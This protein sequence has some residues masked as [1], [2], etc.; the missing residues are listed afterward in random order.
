MALL[1]A[2]LA[3]Q[4]QQQATL[5]TAVLE[6]LVHCV[7]HGLSTAGDTGAAVVF[8]AYGFAWTASTRTHGA[9]CIS[10]PLLGL[11]SLHLVSKLLVHAYPALLVTLLHVA[12]LLHPAGSDLQ[13]EL[14]AVL[15]H[16]LM[17][18]AAAL[19]QPPAYAAACQQL[20]AAA[21]GGVIP[22]S[23]SISSSSNAAPAAAVV[24]SS[25]MSSSKLAAGLSLACRLQDHVRVACQQQGEQTWPMSSAQLVNC[26]VS[27]EAASCAAKALA[28]V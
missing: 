3:K 9:C 17:D 28:V 15:L 2:L 10:G 23:S 13:S 19:L 18:A 27:E 22:D 11:C 5:D 24:G 20:V 6:Q 1:A 12:L 4:Q 14:Q 8:S 16:P 21:C 26:Q 7:L 25:N